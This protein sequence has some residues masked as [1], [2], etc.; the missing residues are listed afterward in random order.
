MICQKCIGV[1]S[2]ALSGV[3][4]RTDGLDYYN[5]GAMD[6]IT[7]VCFLKDLVFLS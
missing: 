7:Y 1:R 5:E 6:L 3:E 2:I 4:Q